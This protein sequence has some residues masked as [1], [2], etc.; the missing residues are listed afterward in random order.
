MFAIGRDDR[1]AQRAIFEVINERIFIFFRMKDKVTE[2]KIKPE[3]VAAS[4][5]IKE[6]VNKCYA[7]QQNYV[8]NIKDANNLH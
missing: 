1:F 8:L 3:A 7:T 4:K 2:I 5:L 6:F